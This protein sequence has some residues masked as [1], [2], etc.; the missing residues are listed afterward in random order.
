MVEKRKGKALDTD[1]SDESGEEKWNKVGET[2]AK[3]GSAKYK[4]KFKSEWEKLYPVRCV[5]NNP[6]YFLCIPCNKQ[7]SCSH[8]G[9][10]DFCV[11]MFKNI[12]VVHIIWK[13]TLNHHD[14]MCHH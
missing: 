6:H 10:K 9:L 2:K 12:K 5:K 1:S 4:V 8:Q 7:I 3:C 11:L 14:L 13:K